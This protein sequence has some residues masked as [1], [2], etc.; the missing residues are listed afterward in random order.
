MY[1]Y[2]LEGLSLIGDIIADGVD[3]VDAQDV[4]DVEDV[5][6]I[7]KIDLQ[8]IAI[9][10]GDLDGVVLSLGNL[11]TGEIVL[12]GIHQG[13]ELLLALNI[14]GNGID[15]VDAQNIEDI[16]NV[17]DVGDINVSTILVITLGL[18]DSTLEVRDLVEILEDLGEVLVGCWAVLHIVGNSV[19]IVDRK[20][21]ELVEQSLSIDNLSIQTTSL[22][23]GLLAVQ[24]IHDGLQHGSLPVTVVLHI[25]GCSIDVVDA[26]N[27]LDI[28]N[29]LEVVDLKIKIVDLRQEGHWLQV[30]SIATQAA[31][32]VAKGRAI[33][34]LLAA[35]NIVGEGVDIV[36][37]D[38]ILDIG[39]QL[40]IAAV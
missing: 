18:G 21:V 25:V 3:I 37:A 6:G 19:D 1:V 24:G 22:G 38:D 16:G 32:D 33:F 40:S 17:L 23:L 30:G 20:E 26:H 11:L 31:K 5:L 10:G 13:L 2:L 8:V 4:P 27:V 15:I 7:D 12:H 28:A 35:T 36:D 34:A 9:L 29:I 14:I 39:E